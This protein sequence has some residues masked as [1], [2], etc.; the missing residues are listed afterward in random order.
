MLLMRIGNKSVL[1]VYTD[2]GPDH[3]NTF[4]S[5]QLSLITLFLNLNL[6]LLNTARTAPH[7]SWRNLVECIMSILNLGF[8]SIG[9]MRSQMRDEAECALKNCNS[10]AQL[11]TSGE[12][13]KGDIKKSLDPTITLLANIVQRLKLKGKKFQVFSGATEDD[14]QNFWEVLQTIEDLTLTHE[15]TPKKVIKGKEDLKAFVDHCCIARHHSFSIKKCGEDD[16]TICKS[17]RMPKDGFQTLQHLMMSH[18]RK[19]TT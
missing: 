5:V 6:D 14:I 3:C 4:V 16:C 2:G 15:D 9:L 8:Q 17:V 7:Q 18:S 11:R 19:L 10:F 12:S 13:Y 1:L